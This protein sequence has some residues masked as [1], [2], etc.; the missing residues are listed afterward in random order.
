MNFLDKVLKRRRAYRQVFQNGIDAE[1]VLIDLARFCYALKS[2]AKF[3][4]VRGVIDPIA[5]AKADGRREVWLRIQAHLHMS[6][7]DIFRL[8]EAQKEAVTNE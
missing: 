5:S 1:V 7:A 3:S 2:T 8:G 4:P 6:D